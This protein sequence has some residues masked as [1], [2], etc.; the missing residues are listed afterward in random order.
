[1]IWTKLSKFPMSAFGCCTLKSETRKWRVGAWAGILFTMFWREGLEKYSG[2]DV[3]S[4]PKVQS[5]C[6]KKQQQR[7]IYWWETE[8]AMAD[9]DNMAS[10]NMSSCH[11]CVEHRTFEHRK[12]ATYG[13]RCEDHGQP[14]KVWYVLVWVT[15]ENVNVVLAHIDLETWTLLTCRMTFRGQRQLVMKK[16]ISLIYCNLSC[17]ACWT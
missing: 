5:S 9:R 14:Q 3:T 16:G 8:T 17:L 4:C 15:D 11:R 10:C 1:M 12:V 2:N 13:L 7:D 6:K